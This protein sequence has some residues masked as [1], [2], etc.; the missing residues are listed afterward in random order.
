MSEEEWHEPNRSGGRAQGE[1]EVNDYQM[2]D[3][4]VDENEGEVDY[5]D[6]VDPAQP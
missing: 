3:Y 5:L 4:E 6:K 2:Y 1:I